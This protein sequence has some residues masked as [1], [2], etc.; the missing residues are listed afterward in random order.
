[1]KRLLVILLMSFPF[2]LAQAQSYGR[3]ETFGGGPPDRWMVGAEVYIWGASVSGDTRSGDSIDIDFDELLED[4]EMGFMG[5]LAASR[6][7]WTVFADMIY[8]NASDDIRQTVRFRG[9]LFRVGADIDLQ[10]FVSTLGG[11]YRFYETDTTRLNLTFGARYLWLDVDVTGRFDRFRR[12]RIGD[13]DSVWDAVVGF[14]GKTDIDERWYLTYYADVGGG[15]S[16]STW[17]ALAAINYRCYRYDIV[18]G[19]RYLKWNFDRSPYFDDLAL[20]GLFAG[21]KFSF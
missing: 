20:S 17:Q 4:L 10:G 6:N 14:R 8:L 3:P 13:S 11:A 12:F 18:G 15:D 2:C 1:M 5:T 21:V 19:Y 9:E 16:D 7:E